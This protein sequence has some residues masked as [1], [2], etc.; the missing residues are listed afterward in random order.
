MKFEHER[1]TI[2]H[3]CQILEEVVIVRFIF[4][5]NLNTVADERKEIYHKNLAPYFVL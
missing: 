4:R 5:E 1:H 3:L 2:S